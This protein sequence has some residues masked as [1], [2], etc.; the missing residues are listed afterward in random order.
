MFGQG[1]GAQCVMVNQ[2]VW[3]VNVRSGFNSF[4]DWLQAFFYNTKPLFNNRNETKAPEPTHMK[5]FTAKQLALPSL[6]SLRG[7]VSS[8]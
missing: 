3:R 4:A 6:T 2:N 7:T 5:V 1:L 8:L